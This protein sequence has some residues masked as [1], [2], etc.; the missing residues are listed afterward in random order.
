MTYSQ[1][2]SRC[3]LGAIVPEPQ[4]MSRSQ[5]GTK[6]QHLGG[7]VDVQTVGRLLKELLQRRNLEAIASCLGRVSVVFSGTSS[8]INQLSCCGSSPLFNLELHKHDEIS[9]NSE[10]CSSF[11]VRV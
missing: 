9:V 3:R 10:S 7:G 8:S 11:P 5:D 1:L 6:C 4:L 2:S